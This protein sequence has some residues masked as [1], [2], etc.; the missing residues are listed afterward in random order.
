VR[1]MVGRDAHHGPMIGGPRMAETSTGSTPL[2]DAVLAKL[3]VELADAVVVADAAG[4]I[5]FWNGAAERL[6]G[7]PAEHALGASLDLIIPERQRPR[8]W[9]GYERVMATGTTKYGSDLLRV[10]SLHADGGRRS[11]AFTVTL[12]DDGAGNVTGI[13]AVARDETERWNEEQELR[14]LARA[15]ADP[16]ATTPPATPGS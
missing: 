6:F 4:T 9:E 11:I 16:P 3:V 7:W 15:A 1:R 10:P 14:R 8:H 13:A 5:C 2:D 12:L